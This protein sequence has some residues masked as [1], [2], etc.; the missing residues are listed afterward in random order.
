M[1]LLATLALIVALNAGLSAQSY[2]LRILE[3]STEARVQLRTIGDTPL[4]IGNMF[5][6]LVFGILWTDKDINGLQIIESDYG[7]GMSGSV[8]QQGEYFYQAFG[9][10]NMPVAVP[11][12]WKHEEWFDIAVLN[13]DGGQ[14]WS[15]NFESHLSLAATGFDVTTNPNVGYMGID[16]EPELVDHNLMFILKHFTATSHEGAMAE[17]TWSAIEHKH[18]RNY[19]IERS[20]NAANWE[21]VGVVE[22]GS[23]DYAFIDT[24]MINVRNGLYYRLRV[25][26][27]NGGVMYSDN[28]W[29]SYD[30]RISLYPNPASAGITVHNMSGQTLGGDKLLIH[31]SMGRLVFSRDLDPSSQQEYVDFRDIDLPGGMYMLELLDKEESFWVGQFEAIR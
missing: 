30:I 28:V 18:L 19:V 10:L 3:E 12:T 6:D 17:L 25:T 9:G 8:K 13:I 2:Q 20:Q 1:K 7:I 31:D 16:A 27:N 22:R 24:K 14:P 5:S 4:D 11:E 29:V 15:F 26:D 21:E 23:G